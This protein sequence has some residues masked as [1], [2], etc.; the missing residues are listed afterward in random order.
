MKPLHDYKAI[1]EASKSYPAFHRKVMQLA[2]KPR[3]KAT[4][5][6]P[7]VVIFTNQELAKKCQLAETSFNRLLDRNGV[8]PDIRI[9][10]RMA[11][12]KP[13][14]DSIGLW[15]NALQCASTAQHAANYDGTSS[16]G[17]GGEG[18][19]PEDKE[20]A[21]VAAERLKIR[22][23]VHLSKII[24]KQSPQNPKH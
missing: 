1:F 15:V 22:A 11:F 12:S 7:P 3:P 18:L 21:L 13:L 9:G 14:G 6:V 20:R 24:S 10:S 5:Y 4:P 16:I 19:K 8:R 17:F 23:S 2:S